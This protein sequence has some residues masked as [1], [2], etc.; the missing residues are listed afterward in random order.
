[1]ESSETQIVVNMINCTNAM[2]RDSVANFI[3][4]SVVEPKG[5]L[6]FIE[7]INQLTILSD[8]LKGLITHIIDFSEN[9]SYAVDALWYKL[10]FLQ[11]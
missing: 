9:P 3:S 11:V 7:I 4:S 10:P 6:K 5:L 8:G 2:I 1:M